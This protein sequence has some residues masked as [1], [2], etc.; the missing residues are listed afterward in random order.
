MTKLKQDIKINIEKIKNT[1]WYHRMKFGDFITTPYH[2][3]DQEWKENILPKDFSGKSILDIG[4]ADGFYSFMAEDRNAESILMVDTDNDTFKSPSRDIAFEY[5][6]TKV[7]FKPLNIYALNTLN[8]TFDIIFFFGLFHHLVYPLY[9]LKLVY[10]RLNPNGEL[11][12]E[13]FSIDSDKAYMES[14]LKDGLPVSWWYCSKACI[15]EML[16][17]IGFSEFKIYASRGIRYLYYAKKG[18]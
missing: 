1:G 17:Y 16:E 10:D 13:S 2:E 3:S 11:W 6:D 14:K 15:L 12:L 5:Y 7:K 8:Q 4:C 9:S 18:K